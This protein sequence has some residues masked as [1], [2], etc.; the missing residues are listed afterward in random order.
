ML[1][2][3]IHSMCHFEVVLV[4]PK[5]KVA[6]EPWRLYFGT[7]NLSS[8]GSGQLRFKYQSF[9]FHPIRNRYCTEMEPNY[10]QNGKNVNNPLKTLY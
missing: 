4:G 2:L 1:S 5:L 9:R 6:I 3:E 7:D 8:L 10:D